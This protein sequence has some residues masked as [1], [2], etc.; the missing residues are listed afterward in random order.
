[1]SPFQS[2]VNRTFEILLSNTTCLENWSFVLFSPDFD[3]EYQLRTRVG[4]VWLC[5]LLDTMEAQ[6]RFLP[7]IEAEASASGFPTIVHAVT[8]MR[9]FCSLVG[10]VLDTYTREE[11]IYLQDYRNTLVH[12]YLSNRHRSTV[13]TK[14]YKNGKVVSE[15]LPWDEY[16]EIIRSFIVGSPH[17]EKAIYDMLSRVISH[18][19]PHRYWV[20][21]GNIRARRDEIYRML[22]GQKP[23]TFIVER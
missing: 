2:L 5:S 6:Q 14:H 19:S 9:K 18:E 20:V 1:M 22:C 10:E 4:V 11:H 16:H 15:I 7:E 21:A 3:K 8:E 23:F 12:S 17:W 13:S